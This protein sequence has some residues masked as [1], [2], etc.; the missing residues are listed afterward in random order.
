MPQPPSQGEPIKHNKALL[1]A[2]L[3]TFPPVSS[4]P[5]DCCRVGTNRYSSW[6]ALMTQKSILTTHL[7]P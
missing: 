2:S 5:R 3:D 6:I 7:E 1:Q 4:V